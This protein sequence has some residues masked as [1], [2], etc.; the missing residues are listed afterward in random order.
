MNKTLGMVSGREKALNMRCRTDPSSMDAL[1]SSGRSAAVS[2]FTTRRLRSR[3]GL[4]CILGAGAVAE[5]MSCWVAQRLHSATLCMQ[6]CIN[7]YARQHTPCHAPSHDLVEAQHTKP[8]AC[9][10]AGGQLSRL[11][12]QL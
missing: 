4:R 11:A 7:C 12:S 6:A 3:R 5:W 8:H 9:M 1:T 10:H 2:P